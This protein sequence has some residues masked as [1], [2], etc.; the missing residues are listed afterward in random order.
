MSARVIKHFWTTSQK[1]EAAA[2]PSIPQQPEPLAE[3]VPPAVDV[4]VKTVGGL[5]PDEAPAAPHSQPSPIPEAG[6]LRRPTPE[7]TPQSVTP[8]PLQSGPAISEPKVSIWPSPDAPWPGPSSAQSGLADLLCCCC[9]CLSTYLPSAATLLS[10]SPPT[11]HV[12]WPQCCPEETEMCVC[13]SVR[14]SVY[15]CA[16]ARVRANAG[17]QQWAWSWWL[18]WYAYM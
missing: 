12:C 1:A 5:S 11:L 14:A 6:S 16:R 10:L 2:V 9:C 3:T 4:T 17:K 18:R 13:M 7:L 15:V 8:E